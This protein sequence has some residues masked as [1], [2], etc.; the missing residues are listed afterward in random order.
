MIATN[1][2][3]EEYVFWK[4]VRERICELNL[5]APDMVYDTVVETM[6]NVAYDALYGN[7][8]KQRTEEQMRSRLE[9]AQTSYK[10]LMEMPIDELDAVFFYKAKAILFETAKIIGVKIEE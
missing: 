9:L 3:Y 6:Y 10:A 7:D 8:G 2:I 4:K 1:L 5:S